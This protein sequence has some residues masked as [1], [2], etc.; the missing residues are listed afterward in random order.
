MA[1]ED[2]LEPGTGRAGAQAE[3]KGAVRRISYTPAVPDGA[4]LP[5]DP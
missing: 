4:G 1:G 3:E 5:L 2:S